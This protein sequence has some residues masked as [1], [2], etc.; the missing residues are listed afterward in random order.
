MHSD[1]QDLR[2]TA[3][4]FR[5]LARIVTDGRNERLLLEAATRLE[6]IAGK[7]ELQDAS[8]RPKP[9]RLI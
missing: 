9:G 6:E 2:H 8:P 4:R 1:P 5:R 3:E 7:P